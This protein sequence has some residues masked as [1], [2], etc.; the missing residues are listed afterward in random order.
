[1]THQWVFECVKYQY[2]D[3]YTVFCEINASGAEADNE[4]LNLFGENGILN[5]QEVPTFT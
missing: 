1:M 2:A 5:K 3:A 4:P